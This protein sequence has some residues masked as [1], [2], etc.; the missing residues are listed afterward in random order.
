MEHLQLVPVVDRT[1]RQR[2][3]Y[4]WHLSWTGHTGKGTL[5]AGTCRGPDT[6]VIEH[7]Q[8]VP[9]VD[10]AK[11]LMEHLQHLPVVDRTDGEWDTYEWNT[12]GTCCGQ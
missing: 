10:Q 4:S 12:Y 7:L 5:T 2:D 11:G 3:T 6:H 8:L 9:V 1:H